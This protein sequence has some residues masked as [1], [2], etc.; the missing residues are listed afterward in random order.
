M[1]FSLQT[2]SY[3]P[4]VY[5]LNLY[6]AISNTATVLYNQMQSN[7]FNLWIH[8]KQSKHYRAILNHLY[9]KVIIINCY[10]TLQNIR[11][12]KKLNLYFTKQHN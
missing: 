6:M 8:N 11:T 3:T 10:K 9:G 12:K 5:N 1:S 4:L 2:Q 7:I